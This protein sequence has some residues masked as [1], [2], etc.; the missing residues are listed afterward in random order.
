MPKA[1]EIPV[2]DEEQ[3]EA[4]DFHF[5]L[6]TIERLA[7]VL[8]DI[9]LVQVTKE[10]L[11]RGYNADI[12]DVFVTELEI[13]ADKDRGKVKS[14]IEKVK[15]VEDSEITLKGQNDSKSIST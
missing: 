7:K 1:K 9:D 15:N 6:E 14:E 13:R 3:E 11:L 10:L 2:L 4:L 12:L 5:H 8:G